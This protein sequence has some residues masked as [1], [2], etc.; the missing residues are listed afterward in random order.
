MNGC[1]NR[2]LLLVLS[3]HYRQTVY[4][5]GFVRWTCI[6][7]GI[8]HKWRCHY[9]SHM[10]DFNNVC[11]PSCN[12]ASSSSSLADFFS[13]A[14]N[15]AYATHIV[16]MDTSSVGWMS[17]VVVFGCCP[18]A[19]AIVLLNGG[20]CV[21]SHTALLCGSRYDYATTVVLFWI[22]LFRY[23]AGGGAKRAP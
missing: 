8:G 15:G 17:I 6:C 16:R 7:I 4:I 2:V 22:R 3:R 23:K 10:C 12:I 1:E 19:T 13:V 20:L 9:N 5:L 21:E 11:D 14:H 18:T